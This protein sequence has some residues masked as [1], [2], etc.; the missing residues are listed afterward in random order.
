MTEVLSRP[1]RVLL[2]LALCALQRLSLSSFGACEG[3]ALSL[4]ALP[5]GTM[6]AALAGYPDVHLPACPAARGSAPVW[7]RR[8]GRVDVPCWINRRVVQALQKP[9]ATHRRAWLAENPYRNGDVAV[10]IGCAADKQNCTSCHGLDCFINTVR[11]G[12]VRNGAVYVPPFEGT[13]KQEAMRSIR[14]GDAKAWRWHA[15]LRCCRSSMRCRR[16]PA[17]RWRWRASRS[18]AG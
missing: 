7:Q 8:C 15:T 13:L 4:H 18:R 17:T 2:S 11:D 10:H 9:M 14:A 12:C 6:R 5:D 16:S 1:R 3:A